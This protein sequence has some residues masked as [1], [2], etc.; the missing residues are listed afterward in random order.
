LTEWFERRKDRD[1]VIKLHTGGG[2]TLV[3]LLIAQ[4]IM[5]ES[6]EP[7]LYLCPTVQLVEQTLAKAQE[8]GISA[9]PYVKKEEF[10]EEFTGA[11]GV[12]VCV[13]QA[14]FNGNSRFG[15]SGGGRAITHVGGIILD[16]AHVAFSTVREQYTLRIEKKSHKDDYEEITAMFRHDFQELGRV[17][18]LDD[19][20]RGS[21]RLSILEVPYWS[22]R[23]RAHQVREYLQTRDAGD[24]LQWLFLRD[25]F[26]YCHCLINSTAVV[27]TPLFPMVDLL[28]T[29]SECQRRVFMSATIGDD[30][31]IVRTFDADKDS[32][33]KPITS[34]S[35][36]GVSERM[37][38]LPELTDLNPDT[39]RPTIDKIASH[40]V[41]NRKEGVVILV[42][43]D[44]AA[45]SW[46]KTGKFATSTDQVSSAVAE[47]QQGKSTGPFVFANR[48]DGIDLPGSSC[49]LLIVS[50][51]P[52]GVGE[53]ELYRAN[54]FLGGSEL[55]STLAQRLEQGM[56]RGARGAGDYCVVLLLGKDLI[57]WLSRS[58]NQNLLTSSTRAQFEIGR[59]V[60]KNVSD[61]S[62]FSKTVG[63]CLKRD[64]EWMEYHAEQLAELASP[65]ETKTGPLETASAERKAFR[66]YREGYLEKAIEKLTSYVSSSKNLESKTKGWLLQIAARI[67]DAWGNSEKAQELQQHAYSDNKNLLRPKVLPPYIAT[68]APGQQAREIVRK[69]AEFGYRRGYLAYFDETVSQLTANSSANQ[70]EE[71]LAELGRILGFHAERPEND[72]AIGPDVLWLL[73]DKTGL[74]IE[75]K[76]RKNEDNALTKDQH[77]QLLNAA[78]WFQKTYPHHSGVRVSVHPNVSASSRTITG[79]SKALTLDRLKAL[80]TDSRLFLDIL[81][82]SVAPDEDLVHRAEQQLTKLKLT[83]EGLIEKYLVPFEPH[84]V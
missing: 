69:L 11:K 14:L 6:K 59:T 62:D 9:V 1:V 58:R 41:G 8:Y 64:R 43:S 51:L 57:A 32:I 65:V 38:L 40:I 52:R 46:E 16:D 24:T 61:E 10:A 18:T 27:L 21:D 70:F 81:C 28:P 12:M 47:L 22:W 20:L 78:E 31:A 37:I 71:A 15:I 34:K 49:R 45:S 84:G 3:G 19:V 30:S 48:Y 80:I 33:A 26:E 50:G 77:G 56:G 4:S 29:Y 83:P 5:N 72:Y 76:S 42:P 67:A 35:L 2:K 39:I 13:Y 23:E 63:R 60:S 55:D 66:L 82:T 53:Y 17:G 75:A 73:D 7:V 79:K 68:H 25:A 74:I 36:A 44:H 54:T